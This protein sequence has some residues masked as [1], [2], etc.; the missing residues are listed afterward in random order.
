VF[1]LIYGGAWL[2]YRYAIADARVK[3]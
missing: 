3:G 2:Y 1:L